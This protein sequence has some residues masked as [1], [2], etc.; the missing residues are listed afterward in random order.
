MNRP[1]A[2]AITGIGMVTPLGRSPAEVLARIAAGEDAVGPA[3]LGDAIPCR[4]VARV[5][6]FD[7]QQYFPDNK[8]LRLMN[9]TLADNTQ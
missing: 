1:R 2:V 7:A 5:R 8:M 6:D 9:R 3:P 4:G